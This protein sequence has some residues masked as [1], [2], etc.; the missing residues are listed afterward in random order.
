M[1]SPATGKAFAVLFQDLRRWD[2]GFFR[3]ISW[4]WPSKY[5]KP[6]GSAIDQIVREVPRGEYQRGMEIIDKISFGGELQSIELQES[7]SYKG[8]LF[9]AQ[10]GELIYSKIRLKQGSVAVIPR[11]YQQ[12][13]VSAEYPVYRVNAEMVLSEYLLLV[14]R[15][16]AFQNLLMGLS[17]GGSTKTRIHPREFERLTIP[18]PDLHIQRAIVA[19]WKT[20]AAAVDDAKGRLSEPVNALHRRLLGLYGKKASTDVIHSRFFALD[21]KDLA[22]WD[23]KSGRASAFRLACPS[24]RPMGEFIEDSTVPVKPFD[25]PEKDWPVYGVNNKEGVFLNSHQKGAEF[26]AA[27]KRIRKDWFF[28]NPT[29]CN[30]GSLGIVP[31]VPVDAITSPEYQV[32][33]VKEGL[34]E[35]LLP[36]YVAVL[37]QTPFFLDLVQFNR[38]GAVKQRMYTENLM[39]VRIPYLR[40]EEQQRYAAARTAALADLDKART[41][42]EVARKEVEEMILGVKPVVGA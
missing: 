4:K 18:F 27:Y 10:A 40:P 12:L 7:S 19:F 42:L 36:D 28:H 6:I 17:H 13:A 26:N 38:V 24:F 25:E 21:F 35:P 16:R 3:Q 41:R 23:V 15:S 22:G 32:W 31:E 39:Q 1:I 2:V 34:R 29:R 14:L 5:L 33:R 37:I 30:V 11:D 8:R 9:F 20:A